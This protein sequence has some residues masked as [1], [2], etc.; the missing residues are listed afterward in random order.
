MPRPDLAVVI[1]TWH[2]G[3]ELALCLASL[4]EA[5]RRA[6]EGGISVELAMVDN[7]S[8]DFPESAL[9]RHWPDAR[10]IRNEDN[11]GFGP[12]ANQGMRLS[13]AG[14]VLF[15]NPD[16]CAVDDPFGSLVRGFASHPDAVALAPRLEEADGFPGE[17]QASF[18]L[19]HLPTWGQAVRELLLVDKVWPSN[20]FLVRDRYLD[21]D[22]TSPFSVEQPA[23]AALAV[24][25]EILA[26]VEGFDERFAPA[27]FEDVDLC[28]R[29]ARYGS[30][31]YW[32]LA[33]FRHLGGVA[34]RRL[35]YDRFLPM[36]YAN[37][38]RYWRKHRGCLASMGFR[39]LLFA[40]MMLR[41]GVL[42]LRGGVPRPRSE[43]GRAYA[44]VL[45]GAVAG[46]WSKE[47]VGGAPDTMFGSQE[48]GFS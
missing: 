46:R 8:P 45:V 22:R 28:A 44:R 33:R 18:Q 19:R 17:E 7:A 27:W 16:T 25:R 15:L 41:L 29:L 47:R 39:L 13:S 42:P 40:G 34:A 24:R 31:V 5:R 4:A 10:L 1:V 26:A 3:P 32:P 20:P 48:G 14:V 30:L 2:P 6:R 35:G 21:R 9:R 38:V 11:R 23:A 36:Y 43:S 37:S 12:A